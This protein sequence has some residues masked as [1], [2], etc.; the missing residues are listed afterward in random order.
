MALLKQA[1]PN[2]LK[3]AKRGTAAFR[4]ALRDEP[5]RVKDVYL[6]NGLSTMSA[7]DHNCYDEHSAFLIKVEGGRF[8]LMK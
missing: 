3:T 6:N 7:T 2:A 5:E 8:R 4:A 1:I